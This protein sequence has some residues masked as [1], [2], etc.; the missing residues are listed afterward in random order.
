VKCPVRDLTDH[1]K[2]LLEPGFVIFSSEAR[3]MP[4]SREVVDL[5]YRHFLAAGHDPLPL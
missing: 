5:S 1:R 4:V 2:R 3:L